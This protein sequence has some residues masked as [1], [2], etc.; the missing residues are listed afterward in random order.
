MSEQVNVSHKTQINNRILAKEN[1]DDDVTSYNPYLLLEEG[2]DTPLELLNLRV[3]KIEHL[4][5]WDDFT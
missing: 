1:I 5:S 3:K 2:L 4:T